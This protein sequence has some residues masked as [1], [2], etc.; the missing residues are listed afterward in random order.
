VILR[1]TWL[2]LKRASGKFFSDNGPLLA[3][4]LAFDLL[5]FCIPFA[6]LIVS[7]LGY[8]VGSSDRA[9]EMMQS[10]LHE[11]LPVTRDAFT[12]N[13]SMALENRGLLGLLGFSLFFLTSS[14]TFGSVRT[15]LNTVFQVQTPSSFLKGKATDFLII[16][17]ASGLLILMIILTSLL[18]LAKGFIER[19]P[20]LDR[21]IEPGWVLSSDLLGFLFT[22]ALFYFL[23]RFCPSQTLRRPAIFVAAFTGAALFELSKWVFAWYVVVAQNNIALYGAVSGLFFFLVW[24]YYACAVLIVGGEV[25]WVLQGELSPSDGRE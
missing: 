22:L 21:L 18:T 10:V 13:L 14:A 16:F 23:Y 20:F 9:L 11:L 1:V 3:S 17:I 25:G 24:I 12:A 4:G 15:V 7:T 2:V 5:L 19:W 6:F 8:A